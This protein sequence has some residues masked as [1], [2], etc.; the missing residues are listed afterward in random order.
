MVPACM[1]CQVEMR[2]KKTGAFIEQMS[3]SDPYR[4]W[5]GDV[6]S[7]PMC[8]AEICT[9]WAQKPV[10]EHYKKDEYASWQVRVYRRMYANPKDQEVTA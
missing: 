8:G 9:G 5:S 7:C 2:P 3:G 4:I 1:K 6:F 10:A